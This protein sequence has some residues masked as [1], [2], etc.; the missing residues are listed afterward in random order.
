[1]VH[2]IRVARGD[3]FP[4][5]PGRVGCRNT[6][7]TQQPVLAVGPVVGQGLA[8]PL[9][10]DQH[11]PPGIAQMIG[12]M[13]F[14]LAPAGSLAGPGV[15]GLDA[16]PQPVRAGRRARLVAQCPGQPGRVGALRAGVGLVAVGDLLGQVLGEVADSPGGVLGPGQHA[17]GVELRAEPGHVRRVIVRADRI[18]G[19]GPRLAAAPRWLCPGRCSGP[20]PTP[21]ARRRRSAR[22]RWTATTRGDT[23]RRS[24]AGRQ[25]AGWRRGWPCYLRKDWQT[26]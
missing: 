5:V 22:R 12:V 11:P 25:R 1:M 13:G 10:R 3:G 14:A 16:V 9:A 2:V 24:P 7:R 8:G 19:P 18:Q 20:R 15:L 4:G 6:E 21:A 23:S 26:P 17:L